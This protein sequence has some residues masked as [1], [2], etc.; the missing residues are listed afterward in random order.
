MLLAVNV[1]TAVVWDNAIAENPSKGQCSE[2]EMSL[3]IMDFL[4]KF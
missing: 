4:P 1:R 3:I 2:Q